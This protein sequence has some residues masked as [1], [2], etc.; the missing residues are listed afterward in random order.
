MIAI[1]IIRF[2]AILHSKAQRQQVCLFRCAISGEERAEGAIP[3]S[4]ALQ[5]LYTRV[6]ISLALVQI[7][8]RAL[9]RLPLLLEV[10]QGVAANV[11]RLQ[12]DPLAFLQ[13]LG[14]ALQPLRPREQLLPLLQM[15]VHA[16]RVV[17]V[18]VAEKRL[19]VVRE[20]LEPALQ[21]VDVGR[22]VAE[23]D[24]D[25]RPGCRGDVLLLHPH[26]IELF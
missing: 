15:M 7:H 8:P 16:V 1:V 12:R 10:R 17:G 14:T 11:L 18:A 24:V 20:R 13:P 26:L 4:H 3:T 19:A 9:D 2:V 21:L 5:G 22:I 25:F 23:P 6:D